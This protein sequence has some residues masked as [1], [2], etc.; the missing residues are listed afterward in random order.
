[1]ASRRGDVNI[2][3]Q[4]VSF[5]NQHNSVLTNIPTFSSPAVVFSI[6]LNPSKLAVGGM[7]GAYELQDVL[8][9]GGDASRCSC[10]CKL[11]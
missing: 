8:L 1:M 4:K 9:L 2:I 6:N 7:S 10:A 11:D 5:F 3:N